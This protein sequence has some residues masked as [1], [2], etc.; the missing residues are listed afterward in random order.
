MQP[1]TQRE[2]PI[3][4]QKDLRRVKESISQTAI[5]AKDK[6]SYLVDDAKGK[7]S[8]LAGKVTTYVK[9]NPLAAVGFSLLAGFLVA[10]VLKK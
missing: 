9:D 1:S 8:E 5:H 2:N 10:L 3:D 7:T 6:A 4:L